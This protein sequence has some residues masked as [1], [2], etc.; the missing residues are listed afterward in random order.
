MSAPIAVV[1]AGPNGLAAAVALAREGHRVVVHEA[2]ETIGGGTRSE[3]LTLPGF[4]HDVCSAVHPMGAASPF[5]RSLDLAAHGLEWVHPPLP[6]AHPFDDGSAAVLER[7][8]AA[9]A[10]SLGPADRRPYRRLMDPLV[11]HWQSVLAEALAPPLRLPRHPLLMARL[12]LVGLRPASNLA[13]RRFSGERARAFFLGIA[14]HT[15]LPMEKAPSAAFGL[16]L[17]LAGHGAGWPIARGG[18]QAITRALA[19]RLREL[20]GSILTGSPVRDIASLDDA[21]AVLLDLTPRQVLTVAGHRLP[22]HY[23]RQLARYRYAPGVF[24][25]DWALREPIPWRAAACRRAGTVHLGGSG[26]EIRRSAA[27]AWYGE[28]DERPFVLLSQ[29][30]LFDP[31]RAPAGL[32]TAWAY[33]HVPHGSRRD[34]AAAIERQVERFAPGFSGVILGRHTLDTAALETHD[35]NLVGGDISGGVQ[36]LRQLFFRPA[37]R[38][39]PYTT[40]DP[41]LFL[42]SAATPPGA[43]VH[44]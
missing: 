3:E 34:M 23:R 40:P 17:A 14:S 5:F 37:P 11:R 4:V 25:V 12:A 21:R 6:L 43:G 35:E 42:C 22:A 7:S 24:K 26:D 19:G 13:G 36:D 31:S 18:S 20:G 38:L 44:G 2:A 9:T 16:I 39:D 28:E 1:G 29:P 32:H 41:R 27:A 10:A 15:L 33:C 30:S 8:P